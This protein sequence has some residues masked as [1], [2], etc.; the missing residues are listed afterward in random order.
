MS[1]ARLKSRLFVQAVVR[2][3]GSMG[4]NAVVVRSG[5]A[6]AGAVLVKL[7]QAGRRA[8]VLSQTRTG[9]GR[10]AWMRLTGP[11]PIDEA[12]AD[13]AIERQCRYDTDLW[14]IEIEDRDGRHPLVDPIL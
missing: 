5:D 1:E 10:P 7:L 2:S 6:D 9:E 12:Q 13:A 14:V 11:E 8:M 4:A 3:C